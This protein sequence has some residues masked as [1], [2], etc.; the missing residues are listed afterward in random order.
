MATSTLDNGCEIY[1]NSSIYVNS[2]SVAAA[3]SN[4]CVKDEIISIIGFALH[5]QNRYAKTKSEA[6][7]HFESE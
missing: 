6:L 5:P 2:V 3:D 7:G 4:V 1:L